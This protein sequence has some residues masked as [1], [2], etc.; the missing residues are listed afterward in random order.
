MQPDVGMT[1]RRNDDRSCRVES[2]GDSP[3]QEEGVEIHSVVCE[4]K[5][6][7]LNYASLRSYRLL[8][9]GDQFGCCSAGD[10]D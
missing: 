9:F 3:K 5:D 10:G 6:A 1:E 2:S 8:R 7:L 4:L